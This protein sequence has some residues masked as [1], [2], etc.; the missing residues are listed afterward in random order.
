MKKYNLPVILL[1]GIILLPNNTLKLEFDSKNTDNNVIDMSLLFHNNHIL[2]VSEYSTNKE[3]GVL[4]RI[5]NNL[6]LPNGNTRVEIVGLKRVKIVE[7]LNL[8]KT[9]EP[10]ESIV[11]EFDIPKIENEELIISK[12]KKELKDYIKLIPYVSNSILDVIEKEKD[13]SKFV[14]LIIPNIITERKR[15]ME[16]LKTI[17][18]LKRGEMLLQDIY[19][20]KQKFQIERNLDLKVKKELDDNQKEF[21]LKEKLKFIKE[22]LG[23]YSSKDGEIEN[24]KKKIEQLDCPKKIKDRL[25]YELDRYE[26]NSS[27]S[28]ESNVIR[29]Y[30]DWLL[31]LPWN[32]F[33]TDNKD[34]KKV[35][36]YLDNSHY[37]LKEVKERIIEYLAVRQMNSNSNGPVICLV[38]PPGVGKTSLAVSIA[39]AINRN[40]VKISVGGIR[41]EAEIIGHR[42]TYIGAS[43]GRII[44]SLKKAKTNNP[45]M[46]IDEIDK[47]NKDYH[48]DPTS[49]LLNILD[50][51]QNKYFSD[52]YIEEDFDLS[53]VLFIL[54]ANY[55]E[56]IPEALRD[57]LEIVNISGYTELE[58]IDIAYKYLLPKILKNNGLKENYININQDTILKIIRNYT[59]EA[60]VRELERQL[61]KIIR[62]I[63]TQIVLNNIK[64]NKININNVSLLKYLG[65]EKYKYNKKTKSQVGVVNGL[66]YTIYGGDI[67][68]IEVTYFKGKGN[69][70]LTGNLG[71][72]MKES[73]T[74]ALNYV[75]ANYKKYGINYDIL[76]NNDIHIH[77]PEGAIKKDGPSAGIALTLAIISALTNKKISSDLALTGEITLRGHVLAIGGLKEKVIGA[78]RAGIKTI[79]IPRDN[80]E[81]LKDIPHEV[82]KDIKFIMVKEFKEI[83]GVINNDKQ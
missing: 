21:I 52:N 13:L 18:P 81:Q 3:I 2:V 51:E 10:L 68:P 58:K 37:G 67:L 31:N 7:F 59:K 30:I 27:L 36:E 82:T 54:T 8:S 25:N 65:T 9:N 77:V 33:T 71:S 43:P 41:D 75:K 61:D 22:E 14:D 19:L 72:V 62:K 46:L 56:D 29:D 20:E 24:L 53:N 15:I 16:Y 26:K 57:R 5:K 49:T 28:P 73:A 6:E 48:G 35:K 4:A 44:T 47:M 12:I 23:E 83:Y 74:I 64:I 79:I 42:K 45:L 66:A 50:K 69:L 32:I 40:F 55:I 76:I 38:G 11:S 80:L 63:V 39:K 1:N 34:L 60:G 70:V 17:E 78:L